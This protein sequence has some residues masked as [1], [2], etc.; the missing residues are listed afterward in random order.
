[1]GITQILVNLTSLFMLPL[2]TKNLSVADYGIWVQFTTT[3]TL[4]SLVASLGLT[5]TL[6]RFLASK[7]DINKIREVFYSIFFVILAFLVVVIIILMLLSHPIADL[8]FNSAYQVAY[9]LPIVLFFYCLNKLLMAYFNAFRQMK[10]YSI[11]LVTQSYLS[12]GVAIFLIYMGFGLMGAILGMLT[13][14]I[15]LFLFMQYRI[16]KEIS[17]KIPTF[18]DLYEYLDYG[19]PLL[20]TSL[21]YWILASSDRYIIG[22]L[23]GIAFVGYYS[24]GY[25]LGYL[26]TML[27]Y[28]FTAVLPA[29]LPKYYDNG[30]YGEMKIIL[31]NSLKYFFLLAIPAAFGLSLLSKDILTILS[32]ADIAS[33]GYQIT[34]FTAFSGLLL[35]LKE[36][37]IQIMTVNKKTKIIGALW[38][39]A[40]VMSIVLNYLLIPYLGINGA[41]LTT[42]ITYSFISIM[43]LIYSRKYFVFSL[44]IKFIT[45]SILA[46]TVMSIFLY[47]LIFQFHFNSL[48]EIGIIVL[49]SAVIY[50]VVMLLLKAIDRKELNLVKMMLSV[51]K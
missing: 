12:L 48:V 37:C 5:T 27:I 50:F 2:L 29:V 46:A 26:I 6:I 15:L 51:K 16:M 47:L 11:L 30:E 14:N 31:E 1:M 17:F 4:L 3:V 39:S 13:T 28:P 49:V 21:S 9:L 24:P 42:I 34:F 25:A 7:K 32:T 35:G 8:I 18:K 41:G 22:I 20:P 45:K 36:I 19:L 33:K 23:L 44:N 43:T 38:I 10:L 40:S